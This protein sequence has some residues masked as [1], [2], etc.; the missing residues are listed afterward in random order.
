MGQ[1]RNR[2]YFYK[3]TPSS[4]APLM[5]FTAG[6][7]SALTVILWIVLHLHKN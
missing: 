2:D 3:G 7:F 1:H 5:A 6:W 4:I